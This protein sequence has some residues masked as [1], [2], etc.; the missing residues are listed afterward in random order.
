MGRNSLLVA[1][2]C[3]IL[4]KEESRAIIGE[5]LGQKKP[6]IREYRATE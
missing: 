3:E 2:L 5:T 1:N 4:W 6:Y